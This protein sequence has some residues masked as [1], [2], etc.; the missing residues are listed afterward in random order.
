[1]SA[2]PLLSWFR[3]VV[4]HRRLCVAGGQSRRHGSTLLLVLALLAILTLMAMTLSYISKLEVQASSNAAVRV[5]ARMAAVTGIPV[6]AARLTVGLNAAE[7]ARK[8]AASESV[9][10]TATQTPSGTADKTVARGDT[11]SQSQKGFVRNEQTGLA[12]T[13]AEDQ[14]ALFNINALS[15]RATE[16]LAG[17]SAQAAPG[18]FSGPRVQGGAETHAVRDQAAQARLTSGEMQSVPKGLPI[19][20]LERFL[21]ERLS[22]ARLNVGRAP[23]LANAIHQ[24]YAPREWDYEARDRQKKA[25]RSVRT[26]QTA[27]PAFRA[28]EFPFPTQTGQT[29]P[30]T[31][32][33]ASETAPGSHQVFDRLSDLKQVTGM[34][35]AEFKAIA[36]YLTTFSSS[37]D[38]WWAPSGAAYFRVPVNEASDE[39][40]YNALRIAFPDEDENQLR[41]LAVNLVD[42]RDADSVPTVSEDV[43]GSFP[44]IGYERTVRISEVCAEVMCVPE[45][46]ADGQYIE[47]HNPFDRPINLAGWRLDWGTG[48]HVLTGVLAARGYL[49]VTNDLKNDQDS[50]PEQNQTGMGSFYDVFRRL[51]NGTTE[52]VIEVPALNLQNNTIGKVSLRDQAGRLIDYLTFHNTAF[53]GQN[54]GYRKSSP[55][56]HIGAPAPATPFVDN[57]REPDDPYEAACW[58]VLQACMDQPF[59]SVAE[60]LTVPVFFS[61]SGAQEA[62][63]QKAFPSLEGADALGPRLLDCFLTTSAPN[64]FDE[65]GQLRSWQMQAAA[66]Q[67]A[68]AASTQ[69]ASHPQQAGGPVVAESQP[70]LSTMDLI[71]S[72]A[73]TALQPPVSYG[74]INLN[75]APAVVLQALPGLDAELAARIVAQQARARKSAPGQA[76][77]EAFKSFADFA[78]A[79][80]VWT[81]VGQAERLEALLRVL[82]LATVNSTAFI[83][84]SSN[85]DGALDE[86][87][88]ANREETVRVS[89][90]ACRALIHQVPGLGAIVLK[91]QF[92]RAWN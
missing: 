1:M 6:T 9:Q 52:Q 44:I 19:E 12:N 33:D 88:R 23:A 50:T 68:T 92:Q 72:Q 5:Q 58:G 41:Q 54:R 82:P 25:G 76:S 87:A 14:S 51:P 4:R 61:K 10:N 57:T 64:A 37:L 3:V 35:D 75:T 32:A 8:V 73:A 31:D 53:T 84:T 66:S 2:R 17:N 26:E 85:R 27:S 21:A 81:G 24:Y 60:V 77:S 89:R 90:Q 40:I 34:S 11:A 83:V 36:P 16:T 62:Q 49:I 56:S 91:W 78:R 55:F 39:Q 42:R 38:V 28:Q 69:A 70:G 65:G 30:P 59:R 74:K 86:T 15:I 43:K 13:Q 22:A 45:D 7:S 79:P 18:S 47:L 63:N 71:G 67:S 20:V 48:G 80:E 29:L 46:G